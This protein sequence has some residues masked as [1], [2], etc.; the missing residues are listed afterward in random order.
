MIEGLVHYP[1]TLAP[2]NGSM[3]VTTQCADN[4][5]IRSGSNLNVT[6][7]SNGSWSGLTPQCECD[8]GYWPTMVDD[9][10]ICKG[11]EVVAIYCYYNIFFTS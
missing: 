9:K 8:D 10:L 1:A 6:C 5:H 11:F 2:V 4:A 7:V 3:T